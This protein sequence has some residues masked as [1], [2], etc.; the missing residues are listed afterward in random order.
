[1]LQCR[2]SRRCVARGNV[3]KPR[4]HYAGPRPEAAHT[5]ARTMRSENPFRSTPRRAGRERKF[6]LFK[7]YGFHFILA[8]PTR[9]GSIPTGPVELTLL[10]EGSDEENPAFFRGI[11]N[12]TRISRSA[13][14]PVSRH[15]FCLNLRHF[16][17]LTHVS[18]RPETASFGDVN[19]YSCE[20]AFIIAVFSVCL[21]ATAQI[22]IFFNQT[23]NYRR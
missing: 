12:S 17:Y 7:A 6:Q 16:S 21:T 15:R 20:L 2:P 18:A 3:K 9:S 11:C 1:M 22:Q 19:C 13:R 5:P 8:N 4:S 14:P 10:E 23:R